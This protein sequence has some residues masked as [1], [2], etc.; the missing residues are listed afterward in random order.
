MIY[1]TKK[2]RWLVLIVALGG[3]MLLVRV[4]NLIMVN[5]FHYTETWIHFVV[6]MVY[7]GILILLAYPVY[8]EITTT[9]LEIRSGILLH[10]KIPLSSIKLVVPTRSPLSSPAWS[11]D[12][13][14]IDYVKNSKKRVIMISPQDKKTF[15][16]ELVE[17]TPSLKLN[18]NMAMKK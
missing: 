3:V 9:T 6:S 8:Y 16:L 7:F 14:K 10:Y 13:L 4:I 2:D 11:L 18:G 5:G 15:L 1:Q 17:R 12:R